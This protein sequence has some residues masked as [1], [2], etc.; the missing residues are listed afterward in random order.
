M[1]ALERVVFAKVRK[2][3]LGEHPGNAVSTDQIIFFVN[4]YVDYTYVKK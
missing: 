1:I 4:N 3:M 2:W